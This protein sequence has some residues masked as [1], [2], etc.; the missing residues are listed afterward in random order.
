MLRLAALAAFVSIAYGQKPPSIGV[1]ID[2]D[3]APS[4]ASIAAMKKE[5]GAI[6]HS[7]GYSLDWRSLRQNHGVESF[8]NVVVVKF[9]GRC[10][11]EFPQPDPADRDT[12]TL[13]STQVSDGHVLPYSEVRCDEVRKVLPY[14]PNRP[15]QALG[16]AL[17]RVVAH[18]LYHLVAGTTRHAAAGLTKAT[19][20][21]L[22]LISGNVSL[23]GIENPGGQTLGE[24]ALQ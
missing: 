21:W 6:M 14:A 19:H 18:E 22:E 16:R 13:A 11:L 9:R 12:V 5:A 8:S 15:Q 4:P 24:S 2:F 7:A 3:A 17:G 10:R 23:V 1:F 20:N